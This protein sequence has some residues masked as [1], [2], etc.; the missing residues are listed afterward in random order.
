LY[1][2]YA[3]ERGVP[4]LLAL[5][6]LLGRILRDHWRAARVAGE[7]TFILEAVVAATIGLAVGGIFEVN[8]GDSE[9]LTVFLVLVSLGYAAIGRREALAHG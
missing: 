1:I 3:A 6:W 7:D 5:L 8:L 4:A 9:V 2:H